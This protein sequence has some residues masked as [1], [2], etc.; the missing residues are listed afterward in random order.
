MLDLSDEQ[1]RILR[2][3]QRRKAAE[4]AIERL[5]AQGPH[6]TG[7]ISDKTTGAEDA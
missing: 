3:E 5:S 4:A 2:T 1:R 7:S 6:E